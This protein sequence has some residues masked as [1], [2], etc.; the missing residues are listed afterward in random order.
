MLLLTVGADVVTD[1][2]PDNL[3]SEGSSMESVLALNLRGEPSVRV[4]GVLLHRR[5]GGTAFL[6]KNRGGRGE[7]AAHEPL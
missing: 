4:E 6:P 7:S 1:M 2:G 3:V 5:K